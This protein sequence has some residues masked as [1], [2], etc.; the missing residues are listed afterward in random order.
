MQKRS[1]QIDLFPFLAHV[2]RDF[3]FPLFLFLSPS[4]FLTVLLF[5][6]NLTFDSLLCYTHLWEKRRKCVWRALGA[7]L[8]SQSGTRDEARRTQRERERERA[9]ARARAR[10]C[11]ATRSDQCLSAQHRLCLLQTIRPQP[12]VCVCNLSCPALC[13][14]RF[15]HAC[16]DDAHS[17]WFL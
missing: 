8:G 4:M 9:R 15:S 12:D 3:K 13:V 1:T 5:S 14:L 6:L 2:L 10:G 16:G 17:S 7:K 11:G